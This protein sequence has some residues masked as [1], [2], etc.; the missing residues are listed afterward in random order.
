[1]AE[2]S[3][4]LPA[5]AI[6]VHPAL[7]VVQMRTLAAHNRQRALGVQTAGILR[8]LGN[9]IGIG[10]ERMGHSGLLS[11]NPARSSAALTNGQIA[12]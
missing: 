3:R 10:H 5:H 7:G 8:L 4:A 6:N 9:N 12:R 2:V 1:M 11:T